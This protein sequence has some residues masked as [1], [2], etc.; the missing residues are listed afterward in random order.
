MTTYDNSVQDYK[1]VLYKIGQIGPNQKYSI[2]TGDIQDNDSYLG[3]AYT[4]YSRYGTGEDRIILYNYITTILEKAELDH[5][6]CTNDLN[7]LECI[8]KAVKFG[9]SGL[10]N[11]VI[12]VYDTGY[13]S[14]EFKELYK[15]YAQFVNNVHTSITLLKAKSSNSSNRDALQD[16]T[17]SDDALPLVTQVES[18]EYVSA[19]AYSIGITMVN[20]SDDV[21]INMDDEPCEYNAQNEGINIDIKQVLK[22]I[23]DI[24]EKEEPIDDTLEEPIIDVEKEIFIDT[25]EYIKNT[26][27]ELKNVED[28]IQDVKEKIK[29]AKEKIKLAQEEPKKENELSTANKIFNTLNKTI[30]IGNNTKI[31]VRDTSFDINNSNDK[32]LE[33][34]AHTK[35]E[36]QNKNDQ[37][38]LSEK[39][40]N[41]VDNKVEDIK[42]ENSIITSL[43]NKIHSPNVSIKKRNSISNSNKKSHDDTKEC[44]KTINPP[45]YKIR[46][47]YI[48]DETV[49]DRK[50]KADRVS[51]NESSKITTTFIPKPPG[52]I[53]PPKTGDTRIEI[54]YDK[55]KIQ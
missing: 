27:E 49:Y 48:S 51:S 7:S 40:L 47:P 2:Q 15:K 31:N 26:K 13:Y 53:I 45:F 11:M 4:A 50:S 34:E 23:F 29:L 30:H 39:T 44:T 33:P 16:D 37:Q 32:N 19:D 14:E 1:R 22:E 17:L 55:K 54:T 46:G 8:Y 10:K 42:E 36:T 52:C 3:W 41:T 6:S 5:N 12:S 18:T 35:D 24:P 25:I 43:I 21:L 38:N 9:E 28:D 20:K